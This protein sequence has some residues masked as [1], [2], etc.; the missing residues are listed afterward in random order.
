MKIN[1]SQITGLEDLL[2]TESAIASENG[3][4]I[5]ITRTVISGAKILIELDID[6][7]SSGSVSIITIPQNFLS[8][9]FFKLTTMV[10]N[11]HTITSG[12]EFG[13]ITFNKLID[14]TATPS[15]IAVQ[16]VNEGHYNYIDDTVTS[17]VFNTDTTFNME[18]INTTI[19]PNITTEDIDF[20]YTAHVNGGGHSII[21]KLKVVIEGLLM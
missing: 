19:M 3:H 20:T 9:K 13:T 12:T 5:N 11:L 21:G 15:V 17:Q 4:T 18:Y 6:T 16:G 7:D 14:N 2:Y 10:V 8:K 1:S